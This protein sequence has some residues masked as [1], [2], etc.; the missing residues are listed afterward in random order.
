MLAE[1]WKLDTI[2][3]SPLGVL[4]A[5]GMLCSRVGTGQLFV[6]S[7]FDKKLI[8]PASHVMSRICR[9]QP[10]LWHFILV[11]GILEIQSMVARHAALGLF[12]YVEIWF[13]SAC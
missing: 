8:S 5:S 3:K 10:P 11:A 12:V 6:R 1:G 4:C 9:L 2:S 7:S 13:D